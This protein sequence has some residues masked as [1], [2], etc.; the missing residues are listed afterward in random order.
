MSP[1]AIVIPL[2]ACVVTYA[3]VVRLMEP[4][5]P[6][7]PPEPEQAPQVSS[8]QPPAAETDD[9][10]AIVFAPGPKVEPLPAPAPKA[11]VTSAVAA[12]K[13]VARPEPKPDPKPEAKPALPA[14]LVVKRWKV[15]RIAVP[16]GQQ[17]HYAVVYGLAIADD[18]SRV[19]VY[20]HPAVDVWTPA[21]LSYIRVL[22]QWDSSGYA[23][24]II[25][26]DA[27]RFHIRND[28]TKKLETYTGD[29]TLVGAAPQ[30]GFTTSFD[31][32]RPGFDFSS[33]VPIM[34]VDLPANGIYEV[35]P[36][37][38]ALNVV[39]PLKDVWD[40][41]A[42]QT[43]V[44]RPGGDYLAYYNRGGVVERRGLYAIAAD[45]TVAKVPGGPSKELVAR[46]VDEIAVSRDGRYVAF[47]G[48]SRLEVWD[49]KAG[50]LVL[51]WRE[52]YRI[53]YA[54]R[55]T[56]D[57]RF[58]VLSVQTRI[59]DVVGSGMSGAEINASARLDVLDLPSLTAAG[60]V[61]LADFDGMCAPAFA[62]SPNGRRLVVADWKQVA[63]IDVDKA[64]PSR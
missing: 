32:K 17:N 5:E 20:N 39:V 1:R 10:P 18:G 21:A 36:K 61:S 55:F 56:G 7:E 54:G 42:C 50:K 59:K 6:P 23:K 47:L 40:A 30:V 45:G 4:P 13:P 33:R 11:N 44:K 24:T 19:I 22:P 37:T 52:E 48:S 53:L 35:D 25:A 49:I 63:L 34:G 57:G 64:F 60:K 46:T 2:V 58:A 51:D 14:N 29:G 27:S 8:S 9:P 12:K 15:P 16:A 43:V 26:P 41:E 31:L 3:S 38:G 62:F 28:R